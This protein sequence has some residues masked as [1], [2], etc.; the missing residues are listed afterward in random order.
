MAKARK[1]S[2]NR[3]FT[4]EVKMIDGPLME[5]FCE[6]NKVVSRTIQIPANQTL[7][8]LH[9]IIFEA[10]DRCDEHMYQFEFGGKRRHD[11]NARH[12]TLPEALEDEEDQETT[13]RI[14]SLG[15]KPKD[16]FFYWFDFGDDWWHKLTVVAIGENV[17]EGS[18]P[19]ITKRVGESP[20]QYPYQEDDDDEDMD[21]DDEDEEVAGKE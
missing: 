10:F 20:P 13:A 18:Y 17:P 4:I 6:K 7:D 1:T 8:D 21:E 12:Y 5:D 19:K 9:G 3:L 14:G 15:L 11:P 16:V 2:D